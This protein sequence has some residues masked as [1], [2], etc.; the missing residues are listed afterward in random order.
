MRWRWR[1]IEC[2]GIRATLTQNTEGRTAEQT[3]GL[4]IFALLQGTGSGG[5]AKVADAS[6][7]DE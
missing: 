6:D 2:A 5:P 7:L 4:P 1:E 3:C